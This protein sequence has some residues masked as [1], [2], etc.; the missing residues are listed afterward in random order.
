M[1]KVLI[2]DET[3]LTYGTLCL[4]G[5]DYEIEGFDGENI[6]EYVNKVIEYLEKKE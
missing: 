3:K 1:S 2:I 5:Q 4:I 6:E